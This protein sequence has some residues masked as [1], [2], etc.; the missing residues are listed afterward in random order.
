MTDEQQKQDE[1]EIDEEKMP[2]E[3]YVRERLDVL[4]HNM[5]WASFYR[6]MIFLASVIAATSA[7]NLRDK[8]NQLEPRNTYVAS[9]A[10]IDRV[11]SQNSDNS[12]MVDTSYV[13][14]I[15]TSDGKQIIFENFPINTYFDAQHARLLDQRTAKRQEDE[16]K[17]LLKLKADSLKMEYDK[18]T[19]GLKKKYDKLRTELEK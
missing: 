8:L 19:T 2:F 1:T 13:L 15:A 6:P 7:Y 3:Q 14:K 12:R 11:I 5:N 10:S 16:R 17:Y 9:T 4:D 18:L